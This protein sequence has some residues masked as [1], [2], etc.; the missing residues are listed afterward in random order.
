MTEP[1]PFTVTPVAYAY[2]PYA[3]RDQAPVQAAIE[4]DAEARI[5][6]EP[7][8]VDA[9][10][11]LD[12]FSHCWLLAW[13]GTRDG[14]PSLFE[15]RTVPHRLRESGRRVGLFATRAPSRP[16]PIGLSLVRLLRVEPPSLF[17]RGVDLLDGTPIV[18]IK[19]YFADADVPYG[20][21]VRSGWSDALDT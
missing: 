5:D 16:S 7:A 14:G 12:G 9:L 18:D 21:D 17:V 20:D 15:L 19:P 3:T 11:E 4:P 8:Y 1:A 13:L 2:T 6:V 10:Q